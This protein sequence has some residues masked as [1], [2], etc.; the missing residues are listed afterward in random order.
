M[1]DLKK[2]SELL[3]HPSKTKGSKN[4]W[5]VE[6]QGEKSRQ[7]LEGILNNRFQNDQEAAAALYQDGEDLKGK[8]FQML[9]SRLKKKMIHESF[10]I[11]P[12]RNRKASY[13][14]ALTDSY[15]SLSIVKTFL[16]AGLREEAIAILKPLYEDSL[17][18]RFTDLILVSARMLRYHASLTGTKE[19]M[20]EYD[21]VLTETI[22]ELDVE[23]FSEKVIEELNL[24]ARFSY[25]TR[26][27]LV[28]R[29]KD[30]YDRLLLLAERNK[31]HLLQLN[32]F[33]AG[34]RYHEFVQDYQGLI[35][36]CE[37]C[38]EYLHQHP[39]F[40]QQARFAEMAL[41]K[42]DA[43]LHLQDYERGR[44]YAAICSAYFSKGT[45]NWFVFMEYFFLLCLQTRNL[46]AC[47]DVFR[48]V[49]RHARFRQVNPERKEKW[50]LFEAYLQF[51]L[52][53]SL[54]DKGFRLYKFINEVPIYNR[55]KKGYNVSILIAQ[56]MLLLKMNDYDRLL[57][58]Q[59]SFRNY[60]SRYVKKKTNYRSYYFSKMLL[61][62]LRYNF[63]AGK[64]EQI[65]R[66]FLSRLR[67]HS[68]R[69]QGDLE[70]LEVIPYEQLW[71]EVMEK[72]KQHATGSQYFIQ[73]PAR[74]GRQKKE[75]SKNMAAALRYKAE[76]SQIAHPGRLS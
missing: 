61:A 75:I 29:T 13:E 76:S 41:F 47:R 11:S 59:D 50:K 22:R 71:S 27:D 48:E 8:K 28:K 39:V 55:D 5:A 72:L 45:P 35:R 21:R 26:K 1:K 7:L 57:L 69:Y 25:S 67:S 66:K 53:E 38:E 63:H 51:I 6:I 19:E 46:E 44:E 34:I 52:P 54:T 33:R 68:G 49:T 56:Y 62:V 74:R 10:Y 43:C 60:F 18:F 73:V 16:A 64:T 30:Y 17:R 42:M 12:H 24:E 31:S 2:I 15:R 4:P 36:V 20:D 14:K 37:S 58:K 3:D 23:M 9:K 40:Y 32:C 65:T 70:S